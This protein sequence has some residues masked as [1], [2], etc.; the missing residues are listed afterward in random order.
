M[1]DNT[2]ALDPDQLAFCVA[3]DD[4]CLRHDI[5]IR[6]FSTMCRSPMVDFEKSSAERLR[7]GTAKPYMVERMRPFIADAFVAFLE[8]R[9][10]SPDEIA[11]ELSPIFEPKEFIK[12]LDIRY[13]LEPEAQRFFGLKF[14]PF[15]ADALPVSDDLYRNAEIDAL[16]ARVRDGILFQRFVAIIGS[17]GSGKTILKH[18][19]AD[20]LDDR[21]M[22]IYPEFPAMGEV[23]VHGIANTILTELG[24][25]I[26]QNKEARVR[27]IK[28]ILTDMQQQGKTVAIVLDECHRLHDKVISS[29]K[30]FWEMT[31]GR[32]SR[33]IGIVLFGQPAFLT[34][35]LRDVVFR[36][37]RLRVQILEMP[38]LSKRSRDKNGKDATDIRT[39]LEYIGHRLNLAGGKAADLFDQR[40]L[41]LIC[42][43]AQTPLA[44]GN[45]ANGALMHAFACEE[46]QVAAS[47][48]FFKAFSTG[49]QVLGM[50]RAA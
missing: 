25:T 40:S 11:T 13:T 42:A 39:A 7:K 26:P 8:C 9:G 49:Q 27:K 23:T 41:E 43:A 38:V 50:R 14:D 5:S 18:R 1:P 29:L 32:N 45:L 46:K 22:L 31:N 10:L 15:D 34:A 20:E 3:V 17:T 6:A 30:N 37:I 44:I 33:L 28:E 35:R 24:Q 48:E 19:I 47:M 36:E 16:A 4:F 12:M 2:S 21:A